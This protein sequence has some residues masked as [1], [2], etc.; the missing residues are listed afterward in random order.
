MDYPLSRAIA[1]GE[2][3]P[4]EPAARWPCRRHALVLF[5]FLL[6]VSGHAGAQLMVHPTRIVFDENERSAQ[7]EIINNSNK[8][9]TY[10]IELVNRRMDEIGNLSMIETS[11]PG[12]QFADSMLRY[13]P[14]RVTLEPGASQVVRVMARRPADLAAGEYRSHL[15]FAQ[16]APPVTAKS[17]AGS[18]PETGIGI[19]LTALVGVS[20]PVI[21]RQGETA[22]T[23]TLANVVLSKS[24]AQEAAVLSMELRRTGS[25]SVYGDISVGFTPAGGTAREI[26]RAGGVAVYTPNTLR[27]A[28]LPLHLPADV[29]L[30]NGTLTV[31]YHER[32]EEGGELLAEASLTLL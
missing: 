10:R 13:S 31:S 32:P 3:R 25:R 17:D 28:R 16:Q 20:I 4:F 8:E 12:E 18:K 11:S 6:L 29:V 7:L 5:A 14:R 15:L 2:S 1:A 23:V 9:T 21:V 26:G 30:A 24:S 19:S 27:R 22:A